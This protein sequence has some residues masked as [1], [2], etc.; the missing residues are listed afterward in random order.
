LRISAL[1]Q[2]PRCV[3]QRVNCRLNARPPHSIQPRTSKLFSVYL[4]F[5][6]GN[7]VTQIPLSLSEPLK[8]PPSNPPT[9]REPRRAYRPFPYPYPN[10]LSR[11]RCLRAH[12]FGHKEF[13]QGDTKGTKSAKRALRVPLSVGRVRQTRVLPVALTVNS[14][15]LHGID[16]IIARSRAVAGTLRGPERRVRRGF[17]DSGMN[18]PQ[19]LAYAEIARAQ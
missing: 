1:W 3:I 13:I 2:W 18:E 6:K 11:R 8:S 4:N 9:W 7:C 19:M 15:V 10:H 17:N 14:P 12:S 16:F 5:H